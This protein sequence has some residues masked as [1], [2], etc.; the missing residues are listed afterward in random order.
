MFLHTVENSYSFVECFI[1]KQFWPN[2][3]NRPFE[4]TDQRCSTIYDLTI[5][6]TMKHKD[7]ALQMLQ[8]IQ[9]I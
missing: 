8:S 5:V 6:Y 7:M 2:L 1:L 4:L 3:I 9:D